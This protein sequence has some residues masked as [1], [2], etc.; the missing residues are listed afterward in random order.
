VT[1]I[2]AGFSIGLRNRFAAAVRSTKSLSQPG[3]SSNRDASPT[4]G[5]VSPRNGRM[6]S[7]KR[8]LQPSKDKIVAIRTLPQPIKAKIVTVD[9]L[10]EGVD[11]VIDTHMNAFMPK[12]R[13]PV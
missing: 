11:K 5:P 7:P 4:R 10:D 3:R 13:A 6:R 2:I 8:T 1:E 9:M 12:A